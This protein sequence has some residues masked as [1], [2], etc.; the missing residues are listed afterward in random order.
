MIFTHRFF[1]LPG[2]D[3]LHPCPKQLATFREDQR[4]LTVSFWILSGLLRRQSSFGRDREFRC[5]LPTC[6]VNA[7]LPPSEFLLS[8]FAFGSRRAPHWGAGECQL[9]PNRATHLSSPGF[10][11]TTLNNL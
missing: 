11:C 9:V 7:C 4:G 2:L 3:A 5:S 10:R 8:Q 6:T 1:P